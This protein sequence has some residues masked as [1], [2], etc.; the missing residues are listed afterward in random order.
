MGGK[1]SHKSKRSSTK[2]TVVVVAK[3]KKKGKPKK[4]GRAQAWSANFEGF[5]VRA[6]VKSENRKGMA[7]ATGFGGST[8]IHPS[9][10]VKSHGRDSVLVSGVEVLNYP[11]IDVDMGAHT[12]GTVMASVNITPETVASNRLRKLA[13]MYTKYCFKKLIFHYVPTVSPANSNANGQL[14]VCFERDADQRL[15]TGSE[16]DVSDF[17]S[18]EGSTAFSVYANARAV[19]RVVDQQTTYY[20]RQSGDP[21]FDIQAVFYLVNVDLTDSSSNRVL[22]KFYVEYELLLTAPQIDESLATAGVVQGF[23][24]VSLAAEPEIYGRPSWDAINVGTWHRNGP[25]E[26]YWTGTT[27][28]VS[29]CSFRILPGNAGYFTIAMHP[30]DSSEIPI[31]DTFFWTFEIAEVTAPPTGAVTSISGLK[32]CVW[33]HGTETY[34]ACDV[35][36]GPPAHGSAGGVV[37]VA[38][39]NTIGQSGPSEYSLAVDAHNTLTTPACT[40]W[41]MAANVRDT[42]VSRTADGLLRTKLKKGYKPPSVCAKVEPQNESADDASEMEYVPPEPVNAACG[43]PSR[44]TSASRS[45]TS[46]APSVLRRLV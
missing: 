33:G 36:A 32:S 15:A 19:Y 42:I 5:G 35:I 14:L 34:P 3:G 8:G 25:V 9:F 18:R 4:K 22:G 2:K 31:Y 12:P 38:F 40:G 30:T 6:G 13:D 46:N 28:N 29:T 20:V 44:A 39:Y 37:F 27:E 21:R 45:T 24:V 10:D 16:V 23:S 43:P 11:E 7:L 41:F 26:F 17:F 1:K